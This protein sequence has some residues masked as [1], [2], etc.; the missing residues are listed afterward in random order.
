MRQSSDTLNLGPPVL[1]LVFGEARASPETLVVSEVQEFR[2]WLALY[3]FRELRV[4][5][6]K[7]HNGS[8][9]RE[10]IATYEK[11]TRTEFKI[12]EITDTTR[13]QLVEVD[14]ANPD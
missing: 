14:N 8:G 1:S 6:A 9:V 2:R 10:A 3:L 11:K 13:F 4:P 12:S 7:L 5:T